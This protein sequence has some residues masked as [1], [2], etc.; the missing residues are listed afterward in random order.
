MPYGMPPPTDKRP[1]ERL[2]GPDLRLAFIGA[3]NERKGLHLLLD[4]LGRLPETATVTLD[5]WGDFAASGA[6]GAAAQAA[7]RALGPR[8]RL[9]G[10]F[11]SAAIHD[12]LREAD[13]LVIPSTWAENLPLVLLSALQVGLPVVIA[14]AE[15][16]LD[17]F[18][19]GRVH[20]RVFA[21]NDAAD[22]ACVLAEEIAARHPWDPEAAPR[23]PTVAEFAAFLIGTETASPTRPS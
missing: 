7:A 10:T 15:G 5:V 21:M 1:V 22:L 3:V 16:L 23:V 2:T 8:V 12:V 9:R 17:A 20:G 19:D 4:A 14:R 11:P 18:P 13:F 6:Y